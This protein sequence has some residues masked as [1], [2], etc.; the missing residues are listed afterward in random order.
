VQDSD[1]A[2]LKRLTDRLS[3]LAMIS[4]LRYQDSIFGTARDSGID[5][6][7]VVSL[8]ER[9]QFQNQRELEER[10]PTS[11]RRVNLSHTGWLVTRGHLNAKNDNKDIA[12]ANYTYRKLSN[13]ETGILHLDKDV[14]G[15]KKDRNFVPLDK[16]P[17]LVL[18]MEFSHISLKNL[19]KVCTPNFQVRSKKTG[20]PHSTQVLNT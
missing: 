6:D 12:V 14:K 5:P 3:H 13:P 1:D 7:D 8:Q 20:Y 11:M 4:G 9:N 15:R 16:N 19:G 2:N 18:Q 10:L 17:N